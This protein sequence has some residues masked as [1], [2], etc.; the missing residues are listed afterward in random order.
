MPANNYSSPCHYLILTHANKEYLR[1]SHSACHYVHCLWT[2]NDRQ[3]SYESLPSDYM[4]N[5]YLLIYLWAWFVCHTCRHLTREGKWTHNSHGNVNNVITKRMRGVNWVLCRFCFIYL[6][7]KDI[8]GMWLTFGME[9][10]NL[11]FVKKLIQEKLY[12]W[13]I[14]TLKVFLPLV[15]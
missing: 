7:I 11:W 12:K 10:D 6:F 5:L 4:R 2:Y 8:D 14:K 1:V 15:S 13:S 9:R 3:S